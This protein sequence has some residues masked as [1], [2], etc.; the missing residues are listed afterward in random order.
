[1]V[2][3][4]KY[5]IYGSCQA[6][7]LATVLNSCAAFTHDWEYVAVAPCYVATE[8]QIVRFRA[9]TIPQLDLLI[10]QPVS[11]DYRGVNFSSAFLRGNLPVDRLAL[12][13]QY[14]HW[15]AYHPTVNSPYGLLPHPEG[16][17]DSLVAGAVALGVGEDV[18]LRRLEE[19]GASLCIDFSEIE[20][21]C[22]R[23]L[24]VREAGENDGGRPVDIALADFIMGSYRHARLLHTIDHPTAALMR[25]IGRQCLSRL[26]YSDTEINFDA[27]V[28]ALD[29]SQ[30]ALYPIYRDQFGFYESGRMHDFQLLD[31]TKTY[32]TYLREQFAWF[33]GLS[34]EDVT[35]FF[36]RVAANRGWLKNALRRAFG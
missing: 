31:Q 17:V 20:N 34:K 15:E 10:Y 16:Y 2:Q 18:Y 12:S 25:E 6:P 23:E 4:K 28:D 32:D 35:A 21:W 9:E 22:L 3:R 1:M 5:S 36:E 26:G 33:K 19:I 14:V 27:S 29:I 24:R 13:V 30:L 11:E 7:A 8:E